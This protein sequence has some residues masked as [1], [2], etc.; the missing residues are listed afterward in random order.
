[1][2]SNVGARPKIHG[3]V[4]RA[5]DRTLVEAGRRRGKGKTNKE[6]RPKKSRE[7]EKKY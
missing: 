6:R 4:A 3:K 2:S 1:M 5:K 7:E